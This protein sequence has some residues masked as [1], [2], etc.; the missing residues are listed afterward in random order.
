MWFPSG[1]TFPERRLLEPERSHIADFSLHARFSPDRKW[2]VF[3][4]D[5]VGFNERVAVDRSPAAVQRALGGASVRRTCRPPDA[6]QMGGRAKRLGIC[7][8][9]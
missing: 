9:P 2:V 8:P 3:T 1:R 4:S 7:A 5:R 6:R